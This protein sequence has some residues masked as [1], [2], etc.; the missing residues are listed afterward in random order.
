MRSV[1]RRDIQFCI[2]Q[3]GHGENETGWIEEGK[4]HFI[5][6]NLVQAKEARPFIIVMN[7]GMVQT[8][9]A[10]GRE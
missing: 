6:D 4:V 10:E 1:R 7:N 2:L 8:K 3:H 9:N 5:M